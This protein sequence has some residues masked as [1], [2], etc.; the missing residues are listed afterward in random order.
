MTMVNRKFGKRTYHSEYPLQSLYRDKKDAIHRAKQFESMGYRTRITVAMWPKTLLNK[1]T[2]KR[3]Q[4]SGGKAWRLW[5]ETYES[6][7]KF[8]TMGKRGFGQKLFRESKK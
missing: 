7:K 3:E 8:G 1:F 5:I 2:G 4:S 6:Y